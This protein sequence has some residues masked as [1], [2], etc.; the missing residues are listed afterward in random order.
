MNFP[1]HI[2]C[3]N[4]PSPPD[5]GGAIDMH[6]KIKA[7]AAIGAK[8]TL[9]YFNYNGVRNAAGLENDCVAIYTYGRKPGYLS[10]PLFKPH[11]VNS[12]INEHLIKRLNSDDNPI[13]LEGLHCSGIIPFLKNPKRIVVRMH[14]EEAAYYD[15][16][17]RTET[18]P[19]K[20][21]YFKR[22]SRLLKAYQQKMDKSTRLACLSL[23]D[24]ETFQRNY[25]FQ[26]A[27][28]VPCFIPWQ[29][30][31]SREGSGEYCLYHGN[32][33]V[34]EN[35]E[36]ALWLIKNVF[37]EIKVPFVIAGKAI[38]NTVMNYA[39]KHSTIRCISNP[40]I[41][42]IDELV[43]NAQI[44]VLPSL[45]ATGVKLKLLNALFNG[46]FCITNSAGVAGSSLEAFAI[47]ADS[48]PAWKEAIFSTFK[49]EFSAQMSAERKQILPLYNNRTNAQKLSE[50]LLRY[51]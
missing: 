5:Y 19:I 4:A 31:T 33:S 50:Q 47:I 44:N 27:E 3:L 46:R 48:I 15:H 32:L 9:H 20:K 10:L 7:L 12:R 6:Y 39:S 34:S 35:A 25:Q 11:I 23:V 41:T 38:P 17:F 43:R 36:A 40:T 51:Q 28:F 14:N 18:S 26:S 30:T 24:L 13:L 49:R 21:L 37:S 45:N 22:E 42:E 16:L 29:K 1:L 8:I 2:V